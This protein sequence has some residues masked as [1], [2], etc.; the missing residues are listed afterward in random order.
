M[1]TENTNMNSGSKMV[2]YHRRDGKAHSEDGLQVGVETKKRRV[3]VCVSLLYL[4][5]STFST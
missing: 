5:R 1:K 4:L 2:Q 3:R